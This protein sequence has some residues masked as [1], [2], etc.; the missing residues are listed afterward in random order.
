MMGGEAPETCW[1]T[2]KRQV[3]NLWNCCILLVDLFE[4]CDENFSPIL[5]PENQGSPYNQAQSWTSENLS[6]WMNVFYI[7]V[8]ALYVSCAICHLCYM[9]VVLYVTCAISQLCYMS[10]A[11]LELW[12]GAILT[13]VRIRTKQLLVKDFNGEKQFA[14]WYHVLTQLFT[15]LLGRSGKFKIFILLSSCFPDTF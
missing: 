15:R 9:S 2:H 1:A 14:C 4:L 7:L 13:A 10:V 6:L 12:I 5:H 8:I 3:I 11:C